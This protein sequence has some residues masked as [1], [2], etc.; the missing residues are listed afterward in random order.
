[1]CIPFGTPPLGASA[2]FRHGM[3]RGKMA[4]HPENLRNA[5]TLIFAGP[6]G[7]GKGTY[8]K[9]LSQRWGICHV[10]IGDLIR[11][12]MSNTVIGVE[13]KSGVDRGLLLPDFLV[14]EMCKQLIRS[15][16]EQRSWI[17]DGFPRTVH[18]AELLSEFTKPH[19]CVN[20]HLPSSI[21]LTKLLG[22]RIC[23]TCGD[24]FNLAGIQ[25]GPYDMPAILPRKDCNV[26]K[27]EAPLLRRA[28]DT[29]ETIQRR[30]ITHEQSTRPMIN[31][32]AA[33]GILLDFEVMKGVGDIPRLESA[34]N[35]FFQRKYNVGT[36]PFGSS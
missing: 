16:P 11:S 22:R 19:A 30:L 24:S 10:S 7:S 5:V 25:E 2:A 28:D 33:E 6:P 4:R 21:L 8:G 35:L 20:F 14:V 27:G 32:Y 3:Q 31:Q 26:C 17:L 12:A 9:I 23:S 36:C 18:Q 29:V 34:I 13:T 1:M 15:K